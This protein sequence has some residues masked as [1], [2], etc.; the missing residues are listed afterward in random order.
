MGFFDKWVY[1]A[2]RSIVSGEQFSL[3]GARHKTPPIMTNSVSV[4]PFTPVAAGLATIAVYEAE[5][6]KN[7]MRVAWISETAGGP[8][9]SGVAS[10]NCPDGVQRG[11]G[12]SLQ[13]D[14]G[15]VRP[16]PSGWF[17]MFA[18][19]YVELKVGK[20]YWLNVMNEQGGGKSAG[21]T[22]YPPTP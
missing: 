9:L 11:L 16:P 21:F 10:Y 18:Q 14:V 7:Y 22:G 15:D 3:N 8:P 20:Q 4:H 6:G 17:A 12:V 2:G 1:D 19:K 13:L 5:P